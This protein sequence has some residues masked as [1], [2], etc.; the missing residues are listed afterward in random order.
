MNRGGAGDE[1]LF[2][3]AK[4]TPSALSSSPGCWVVLAQMVVKDWC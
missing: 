2:R 3:A 4:K 1:V